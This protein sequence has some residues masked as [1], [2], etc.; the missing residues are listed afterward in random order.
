MKKKSIFIIPIIAML[1][2]SCGS[3]PTAS[4]TNQISSEQTP[5]T[6]ETVSSQ[7]KPS[8]AVVSSSE[9]VSSESSSLVVSSSEKPSSQAQSSSERIS[10]SEQVSSSEQISSS[11]A[12]S[13]SEQISSSE[14]VSSS[15]APSSS[16]ASSSSVAPSSSAQP[17]S[18]S[19]APSSSSSSS[20]STPIVDTFVDLE[21]YASNDFHGAVKDTSNSVGISKTSTLLKTHPQNVN[22]ALYLSQGDMWQGSAES[23][24][25]K[26]KL[27]TDWMNLV[28]FSSMTVGN[29]DFDWTSSYIKTNAQLANFP[30]L[31]INV[32][33]R[34][35]NQRVDYLN[36]STIINKNGAKIG[37]VG[38]I[39]DCYS[40]ISSSK[41]QDVYF[42]TGNSLTNLVKQEAIRLKSEE[43]CDFVIYSIHDDDSDYDETLSDYVD[44]VLEGHTHQYY[45]R[46]DSRGIYHIQGSGYNKSIG[47][48]SLTINTARNTFVVN[49]VENIWTSNYYYLS[50][51]SATEA[52]FTKYADEIGDVNSVLGYNSV[53]RSSDEI[54]DLVADLYLQYGL[55]K[56]GTSYNIFLGGGYLKTRDPYDL[57]AGPV[58]YATLSSLFTFNNPLQLCSLTGYYLYYKFT[59]T[60]NGDYH[61]SYSSFGNIHR[62]DIDFNA[63]Y[64]VVVDSYTSDYAANHLTVID[65]FD[66]SF[67]ARDMLAE[68]ISN[69]NME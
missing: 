58:T 1:I 40:S 2:A 65:T 23:N 37:V 54:E 53:Y 26:G 44:L 27:V 62:S 17:S 69:G 36:P 8:S 48:I 16:T 57:E 50:D 4:S 63:T 20:S 43:Q 42:V 21:I 55:E 33:D 52:L 13:S 10:S 24:N 47:Y 56:W 3:K 66:D 30:F 9:N 31:G 41:V 5:T 46:Q 39:G 38:A 12:I 35:T 51:D 6:S 19:Q 67:Y 68:Y 64:Y 11:E 45:A 59:N 7:E 15:E 34:T 29:H 25:T 18:S 14:V 60:S 49:D 32:Y 28:G 22:N 61:V